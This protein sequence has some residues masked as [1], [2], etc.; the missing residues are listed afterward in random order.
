MIVLNA[1]FIKGAVKA[2]QF[3]EL[4]YPEIAFVGR[5][6]VGKSSL[7]NSIVNRKNLAHTSSTPGKTQQINFFV[8]EGKWTF[9]DLPGFGYA[10]IGK[11]HREEWAKLN[12][13]YLETRKSIAYIN[14]LIDS[15]H[16]PQPKDLA[17]IEWCEN[18]KMKYL[19]ILTKCDKLK[20]QEIIERKK[21]IDN[22]LMNCS[23]NL[24]VLPYSSQNG[25]GRLE[26]LA[27]IKRE[28]V[29]NL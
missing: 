29:L 28:C 1:E 27:I 21:Q 9:A 14:L 15:R 18:H 26:L 22:L 24:E 3:P 11:Q 6:N 12:F 23:F 2:D 7:L 17:L 10:A 19:I 5:S 16:D 25:M 13:S 4:N 20:K 8:V